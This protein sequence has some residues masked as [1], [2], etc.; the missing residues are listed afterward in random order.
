LDLYLE[1]EG[2]TVG[3]LHGIPISLK[4]LWWRGEGRVDGEREWREEEIG[5]ERR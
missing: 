5:E 4:V 2:K 1:K 3:A